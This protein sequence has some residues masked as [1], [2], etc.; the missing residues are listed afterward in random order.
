MS[1]Y[2][3]RNRHI[4]TEAIEQIIEYGINDMFIQVQHIMNITDGGGL[5]DTEPAAK[6]LL[7]SIIINI[8]HNQEIAQ[9]EAEEE[10]ERINKMR[11]AMRAEIIAEETE[12][13]KH[14]IYADVKDQLTEE[15]RNEVRAELQAA[16]AIQTIMI[17]AGKPINIIIK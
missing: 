13:M 1:V 8:K 12:K 17:E 11:A 10:E 4:S 7:E 5:L 14:L 15:I 3:L 2:K 6:H 9:H 16:Q